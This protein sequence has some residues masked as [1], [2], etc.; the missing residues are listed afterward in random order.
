M[1]PPK[2]VWEFL[3]ELKADSLLKGV[4]PASCYKLFNL[5]LLKCAFGLNDAPKTWQLR[6]GKKLRQLGWILLKMD[7]RPVFMLRKK[8]EWQISWPGLN[9]C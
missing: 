1:L 5:H 9:S 8:Q 7:A 4:H 3:C 6:L 2:G